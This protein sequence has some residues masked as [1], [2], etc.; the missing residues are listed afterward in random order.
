MTAATWRIEHFAPRA[1][2][3]PQQTNKTAIFSG[4]VFYIDPHH[5]LASLTARVEINGGVV[6]ATADPPPAAA[7]RSVVATLHHPTLHLLPVDPGI[8][9]PRSRWVA[10]GIKETAEPF[11]TSPA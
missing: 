4:C 10:V 1:C 6:H 11:L 5:R 3:L 9:F 7:I 2:L 8:H